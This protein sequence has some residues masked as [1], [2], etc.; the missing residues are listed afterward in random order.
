[1]DT[2]AIDNRKGMIKEYTVALWVRRSIA[3]YYEVL[4]SSKVPLLSRLLL[5]CGASVRLC[6]NFAETGS[7]SGNLVEFSSERA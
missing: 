1:M 4:Q 5:C 6:N 7:P 3:S 2:T